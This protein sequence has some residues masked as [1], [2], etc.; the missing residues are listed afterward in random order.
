LSRVRVYAGDAL[1]VM[2][3]LPA[4][5]FDLV[6][7]D[8][9]YCGV[10]D[11][12]W[13]NQWASPSDYLSWI[14]ELCVEWARLLLP[15][16]SLYL[17]ASPQMAARAECKVA[18][19]LHVLNHI[20]WVKGD[21]NGHG[22][23]A[24]TEKDALRSF[25]P[26]K[27]H[28]I[29][30]EQYGADSYAAGESGY[31]VKCDQARGFVFEPIRAYLSQEWEERAGLSRAQAD[32]ACGVKAMASR[33]YFSTIQW[34]MPTREHYLA[35]QRYANRN[36]GD[37]L[38]NDYDYLRLDYEQLREQYEV[39]RG[40][41]ESLRRPFTVTADD[42]YTDCWTAF[43]TVA[44]YPGKHPCEKPAALMEHIILT[45]T[46][47]GGRVLDPFC[48]SGATG[49]ACKR[50]GRDGVLVDNDPHWVTVA[51][52]RVARSEDLQLELPGMERERRCSGGSVEQM[53]LL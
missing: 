48:G 23:W 31:Q 16:G 4:G 51:R 41:Y 20:V 42:Q 53:R 11:N 27:E 1:A 21:A 3:R 18:E 33:H 9:P 50:L 45:S 52:D 17:F 7:T 46:L 22:Q 37:F 28:I 15:T 36:G 44:A 24:R 14:G 8:P 19:T 40:Q 47:P 12:D 38:Q 25:F 39:L 2:R 6:A 10:K 30:A 13:D 5:S 35:M 32:E 29:F 43:P 26:R 34:G 49:V